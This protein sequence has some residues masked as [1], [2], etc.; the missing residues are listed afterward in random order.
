MKKPPFFGFGYEIRYDYT[1][2]SVK[3]NNT[4]PLLDQCP[5]MPLTA[6]VLLL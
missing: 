3:V 5:D 2:N 6:G 4:K 1:Q